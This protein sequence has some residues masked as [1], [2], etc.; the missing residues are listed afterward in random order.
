MAKK[1]CRRKDG[2]YKKCPKKK[3]ASRRSPI[4]KEVNKLKALLSKVK[5]R[6]RKSS[7]S[8]STKARSAQ[9]RYM[10]Q[11]GAAFRAGPKQQ[12]VA[13]TDYVR[14]MTS[15]VSYKGVSM[16]SQRGPIE[17]RGMLYSAI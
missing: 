2:R 12:G 15:G 17:H 4:C 14:Q 9:K 13:W 3:K 5:G 7:G 11:L 10:K 1:R 8:R 6:K 16:R